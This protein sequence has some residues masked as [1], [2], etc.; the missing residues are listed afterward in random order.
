M[1]T[2][3]PEEDRALTVQ[4]TARFLQVTQEAV[5]GFIHNGQLAATNLNTK[6]DAIRPRWRILSSNLG[7]FLM[8]NQSP[9]PEAKRRTKAEP[10][11][12]YFPDV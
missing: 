7:R 1:L 4:E 6:P 11:K 8:K 12:D 2:I 9:A 5:L 3:N 10:A